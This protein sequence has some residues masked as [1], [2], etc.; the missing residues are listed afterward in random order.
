M[1]SQEIP[2]DESQAIRRTTVALRGFLICSI[3]III[4]EGGSLFRMLSQGAPTVLTY[5]LLIALCASIAITI[6]LGYA[7]LTNRIV[8]AS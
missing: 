7:V 6:I 1:S 4:I 3:F 2:E 8:I 5:A